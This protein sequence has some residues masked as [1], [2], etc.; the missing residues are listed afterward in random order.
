LVVCFGGITNS[1]L[2]AVNERTKEIGVYKC[3]GGLDSHI[4]RLFIAEALLLG[5]LG[6]VLGGTIGIGMGL[7]MNLDRFAGNAFTQLL[8]ENI[9][10]FVGVFIICIFISILLTA[11][12][13]YIPARRAAAFSPAEALRYEK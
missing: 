12:A 7:F 1:M 6:G 2:M 8:S 4:V 10:I 11:L 9:G 3:I 13:T 5:L